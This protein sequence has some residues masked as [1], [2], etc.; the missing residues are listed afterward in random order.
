MPP[1]S[2]Q[3]PVNAANTI[4][5]GN[6]TSHIPFLSSTNPV[7]NDFSAGFF[8]FAVVAF[9]VLCAWL[10]RQ[11]SRRNKSGKKSR[12]ARFSDKEMRF[13]GDVKFKEDASLIKNEEGLGEGALWV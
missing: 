4:V 12:K 5:S 1:P 6:P 10:V 11:S 13:L 7:Q 3:V 8:V 2:T 9:L